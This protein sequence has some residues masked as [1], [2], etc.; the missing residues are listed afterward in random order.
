MT[1]SLHYHV[2]S[3]YSQKALLAHYEK[4]VDFTPVQVN[5]FDPAARAEY[6]KLYPLGKIPLLTGDDLFIPEST[7]IVEYLENEY[8]NSG[9]RLIPEDKTAA[10]RARFK[11]RVVDLYLNNPVSTLF[12]E[13]Q[14]PVDQRSAEVGAKARETLDIVYALIDKGLQTETFLSGNAYSI[15]DCAAFGPLFYA[16]QLHPWAKHKNIAAYFG[17]V[18]ERPS[19]KRLLA[20]LLPVLEKF[21]KK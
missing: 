21:N 5:L 11:D 19:V 17:R 13:S 7:T 6:K 12:F 18:V 14:K 3:T 16:Q 10:R 2:A 8:P 1:H 20:E 9:T 4:G 15:A